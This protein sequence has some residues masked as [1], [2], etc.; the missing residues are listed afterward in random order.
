[1]IH[2]PQNSIIFD[3]GVYPYRMLR[4]S[5]SDGSPVSGG[6]PVRISTSML[7]D[8]L[9]RHGFKDRAG[10]IDETIF[11]YVEDKYIKAPDN[12]LVTK[13]NDKYTLIK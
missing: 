9:E 2:I 11:D 5:Y 4:L 3:G 1:M 12:I 10:E 13:L 7:R 8:K 6:A